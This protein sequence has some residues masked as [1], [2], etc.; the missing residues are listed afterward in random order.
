MLDS[1]QYKIVNLRRDRAFRTYLVAGIAAIVLLLACA[2]AYASLPPANFPGRVIVSIKKDSN[3]LQAAD[4]LYTKGIIRSP[5]VFELYSVLISGH[6]RVVA[7]DYLFD[8]PISSLRVAH[9]T[10]NGIQ[11]LPKIRITIFEGMTVNEIAQNIKKS[12]PEFDASS[13]IALAQPYQG[14]L[15]PDTYFFYENVQP[16]DVLT[17][18]SENFN[19]K[20]RTELLAIQAFGKTLS[21]VIIMASLVEREASSSKDRRIISDILWR[22]L[23]LRMPL[24]VDA[25]FYYILGKS[26]DKLTVKDLSVDSAYNLYAHTGLPPTPI[27]NPGMDAI[28]DTIN[29]TPNKYLFFLSDDKGNMHYSET[30]EGHVAN[31]VKYL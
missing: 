10:V 1:Y 9:R 25:P 11:G 14:F 13:F 26:S 16:Q 4:T 18:L 19:S 21:Q 20:I 30:Y 23:A 12:I 2:V 7:G 31:K 6:R 8:A 17:T 24:Q 22:R 3:L 29:P 28:I 5:L 27:T 15:F